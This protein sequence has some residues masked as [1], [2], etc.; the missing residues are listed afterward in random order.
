M[1][2]EQFPKA[3]SK[4]EAED[5]AVQKAFYSAKEKGEKRDFL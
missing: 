5:N 4:E 3:F 2:N 1:E